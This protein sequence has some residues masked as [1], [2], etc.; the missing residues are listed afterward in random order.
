[1]QTNYEQIFGEGKILANKTII[2]DIFICLIRKL[3]AE[4]M[5]LKSRH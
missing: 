4:R 1:M 3:I 2:I 5:N